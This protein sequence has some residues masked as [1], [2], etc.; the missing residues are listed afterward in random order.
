MKRFILVVTYVGD[1]YFFSLVILF[2]ASDVS[3]L[4]VDMLFFVFFLFL[5]FFFF[6][7]FTFYYTRLVFAVN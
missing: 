5:F 7:V 4:T 3:H 2:S 1:F 6:A